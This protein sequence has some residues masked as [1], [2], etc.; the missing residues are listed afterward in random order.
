MAFY[1]GKEKQK[2]VLSESMLGGGTTRP[3]ETKTVS[4]DRNGAYK[5]TPSSGYVMSEVSVTVNVPPKEEQ[6]KSRDITT[7][8]TYS[9]T[10][11][12]NKVLSKATVNVN[13]PSRYDEGFTDGQTSGFESGVTS[14]KEIGRQEGYQQGKTEGYNEGHTAGYNKGLE[15]AEPDLRELTATENKTYEPN[16]FDGYGSVI[17]N[18]PERYEEGYNQGFTEGKTDGYNE[19]YGV[20][21]DKGV[22]DTVPDLRELTATDNITYTPNGFDGYT[23]V[24]VNVPLKYDEGFTDGRAEGYEEGYQAGLDV[25][26]FVTG[27][28]EADENKTYYPSD[29]NVDG[30][31]SVKV[32]VPERY[33]EGLEDGKVI[34]REEGYQNGYN[35]G[36]E[37]AEPN[38]YVETITENNKTYTPKD[39]FD[40]F[41]E[42]IV[43]VPE[44]YDEGFED[45]K[46]AGIEEG[47]NE[48][49][50]DGIEEGKASVKLYDETITESG[51][52][53][54]EPKTGFDGFS[55]VIVDVADR[56]QEGYDKGLEDAEPVLESLTVTEN[57]KTY[58]P[59][60]DIDGFN[61][62]TVDIPQKTEVDLEKTIKTNDTFIYEPE[63]GEVFKKVT[64]NV[65]VP[66]D[67]QGEFNGVALLAEDNLPGDNVYYHIYDNGWAIIDGVGVIG[68][69]EGYNDDPFG[70][71]ENMN[72]PSPF[73][74]YSSITHVY[75]AD[76]ITYIGA[77]L[78]ANCSNIEEVRLPDSLTYIGTCAFE[79]TSITKVYIPESV[80]RI[81]ENAFMNCNDLTDVYYGGTKSEW[82]EHEP[83]G[84]LLSRLEDKTI[85]CEYEIP[86][87]IQGDFHGVALLEEG[88]FDSGEA[89]YHIYDNGWAIIDGVGDAEYTPKLELLN[90]S[91]FYDYNSITHVY[92]SD[93]ITSIGESLFDSCSNVQEVRLPD[94]LQQI[95]RWAF[96]GTNISKIYIPSNVNLIDEAA[97]G[98]CAMLTDVYYGGTKSEWNAIFSQ[99]DVLMGGLVNATLH[100]EYEE[101]TTETWTFEME[102]GSIVTKEVEV[103]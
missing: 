75:I 51:S 17:V 42:V 93:G 82:D 66:T 63:E 18:V 31:S 74:N 2:V 101:L 103:V 58:T 98:D 27:A 44:R 3:V 96:Y 29:Y 90:P 56:Y 85:H 86:E 102:D 13:V 79:N 83:H 14:G 55:S 23:S 60:D 69:C 6:E 26:D 47:Y 28:L 95:G 68:D 36:L 50:A 91:P 8:G 72:P 77:G 87:D 80:Y 64:I 30:F 20:G 22:E 16:G 62:V 78:F 5:V 65:N 89:F 4:Y 71:G 45:G 94:S 15:D 12:Y 100:C 7:N 25:N 38:L 99:F 53:T 57:N 61:S 19:G 54:V 48:G 35:K 70:I 34:G 37:D 11:D 76:G 59:S 33:D 49:K 41:S 40:G 43:N 1:L 32:A 97:F 92:V 24:V 52:Y 88:A 73:W 81:E 46:S 39:D 21:Y 84:F 67:I 9:L 10:P